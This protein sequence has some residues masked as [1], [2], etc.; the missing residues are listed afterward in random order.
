M[1]NYNQCPMSRSYVGHFCD[2]A[3]NCQDGTLWS[4]F[5]SS[6][7][8]GTIRGEGSSLS[9]ISSNTM[10]SHFPLATFDGHAMGL[11]NKLILL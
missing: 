7:T 4:T 1:I 11:R 6:A 5:L 8:M 10:T 3:L 2:Q 9:L